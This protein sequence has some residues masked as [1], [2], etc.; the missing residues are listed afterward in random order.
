[1]CHVSFVM[2][3]SIMVEVGPDGRADGLRSVAV[4][5]ASSEVA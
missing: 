4:V 5:P 1:M 2:L 3:D